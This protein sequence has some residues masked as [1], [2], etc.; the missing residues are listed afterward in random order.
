MS[1]A[2][3]PFSR[4]YAGFEIR[5]IV[6]ITYD[7]RHPHTY[8]PLHPSQA[9]LSDDQIV[10]RTCIFSEEFVLITED[11]VIP[12]ELDALCGGSGEAQAV[13]YSIYGRTVHGGASSMSATATRWKPHSLCRR[14]FSLKPA[15]TAVP[16]RSAPFTSP[17][18]RTNS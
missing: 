4:G 6:V 5:R 11:Q 18:R 1:L 10:Q 17:R 2:H 14:A 15:F 7:D 3:N 16:G 8:Q 12:A 9:H 13:L